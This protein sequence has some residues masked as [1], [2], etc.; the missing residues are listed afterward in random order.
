MGGQCLRPAM[1]SWPTWVYRLIG[2][3]VAI[4]VILLLA[5]MW[6]ALQ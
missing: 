6:G 5:M 2:V 4:A 3:V 1:S